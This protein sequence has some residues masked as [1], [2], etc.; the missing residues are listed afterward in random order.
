MPSSTLGDQRFVHVENGPAGDRVFR[1][2]A[3]PPAA[4][5]GYGSWTKDELSDEAEKRGLPKS[6]TKAE[7]IARLEEDDAA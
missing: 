3:A 1:R 4:S 2:Y 6:G 5:E 7:L